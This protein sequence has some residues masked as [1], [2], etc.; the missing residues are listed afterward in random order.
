MKDEGFFSRWSRRKAQ[1]T[2]GESVEPES[3]AEVESPADAQPRA[4]D[5]ASRTRAQAQAQTQAGPLVPQEQAAP[6]APTLEDVARL[7]RESDYSRFVA[8]DV[9]DD[10][11]R[12]A[13]RKLFSDPHFNKMDGLD[14]YIDDYTQS[15]PIPQ[16]VLRQMVQS[17]FLGLFREDGGPSPDEYIARSPEETITAKQDK[18]ATGAEPDGGDSAGVPALD[19]HQDIGPAQAAA[20]AD[21]HDGNEDPDLQLQPDDAARRPGPGKGAGH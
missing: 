10:I 1:T 11:K 14:V 7:T 19:A 20:P 21:S 5:A 9:D 15:T 17:Q 2:R 4:D 18:A 12:A 3:K 6:P 13:M 16:A 8:K